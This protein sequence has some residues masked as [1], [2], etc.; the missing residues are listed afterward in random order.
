MASLCP[1]STHTFTRLSAVLM[2]VF[3]CIGLVGT[4]WDAQAWQADIKV[5]SYNIRKG[6]DSNK[7]RA[8]AKVEQ[9][10][11]SQL[12]DLLAVQEID[13]K[14]VGHLART[15][16]FAHYKA[17]RG[18]GKKDWRPRLGVFSRWPMTV[19]VLP[20]AGS[21]GGR[22]FAKAV[23]DIQGIPLV[24]YVAHF[25]REGLVDGG[26]KGLIKEVLGMSSR[27]VQMNSVVEDIKADHHRYRILAGDLNTFPMSEP[28][29]HLS[30]VML[31]AFPDKFSK[32]TYRLSEIK[33]GQY[34]DM[35]N[36]KIDHIFY[37]HG[38]KTIKAYVVDE[39]PSDHLPV[40][41]LLAMLVPNNSLGPA[42]VKQAQGLLQSLGM[43]PKLQSGETDPPTRRAIARFQESRGLIIDGILNAD[44][45]SKLQQ[46]R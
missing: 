15:C 11:A 13:E 12:P 32:G 36:P 3:I 42:E 24:F 25:S 34:K 38:L 43:G 22:S 30:E 5:M 37:S 4:A 39:G 28:Y 21:K 31:D 8:I 26:G 14:D 6:L 10:V 19:Q 18:Y 16:A 33:S 46:A 17:V 9:V 41:A 40:V 29:R 44:T 2:G 27:S 20:L 35:P 7:Q 45:W 23:L 1:N